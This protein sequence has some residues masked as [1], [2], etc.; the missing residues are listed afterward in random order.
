MPERGPQ[1]IMER[2][3]GELNDSQKTR[4]R[5]TC[6]YIDKLLAD[7]ADGRPATDGI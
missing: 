2:Q 4:L 5:I 6:Q 3:T 1:L 7:V